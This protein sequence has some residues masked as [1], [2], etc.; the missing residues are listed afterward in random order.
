MDDFEWNMKGSADDVCRR[1]DESRAQGEAI[2]EAERMRKQRYDAYGAARQYADNSTANAAK[3]R[4]S[5]AAQY[6]NQAKKFADD[7]QRKL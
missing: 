5:E 1:M 6:A 2:R 3:L 4:T 7:L